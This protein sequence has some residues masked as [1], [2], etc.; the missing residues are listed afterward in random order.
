MKAKCIIILMILTLFSNS[1]LLAS[2]RSVGMAGAYTAASKGSESVLWNP[3]NLGFSRGSEKTFNFFSF[4]ININNNSFN[5]G[6]YTQYNGQFLTAEDK[7]NIL[8]SIP[9]EGFNLKLD[10]NISILRISRGNFAFTLSGK[11]SSDLLLPKEPVEYLFFGNK[12]NDTLLIE[13]S[14]GEAF[15]SFEISLSY[16]RSIFKLNEKEFFCG[17]NIRIIRGVVYQKV[18]K[19]EGKL[20]TLETGINGDGDFILKSAQGGKGYALDLGFAMKYKDDWTFGISFF[21]LLNQIRWNKG[22]KERGYQFSLDSLLAENFDMDSL[23]TELSY[24]KDIDPFATKTPI[25]MRLGLARQGKRL[26]WTLD[27]ERGFGERMGLSKKLKASLGAEY[28]V[29]SWLDILGGISVGGKDGITLANGIGFNL[30]TYRLDIGLANHKGLWPTKSKG[31]ALAISSEF[32][33]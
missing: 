19:T 18:E 9:S 8:N 29:L 5:W 20:L 32:Q 1:H 4:R 26:L 12:F 33:W 24:T 7:K 15:A 10:A 13:N 27:L 28:R 14:D 6:D 31:I 2:G 22:T 23:V 25:L 17:G 11:G 3:A 30:G 16:G 21:N